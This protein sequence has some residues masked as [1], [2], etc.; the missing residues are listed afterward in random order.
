[1]FSNKLGDDDEAEEEITDPLVI[2]NRERDL[3]RLMLSN[4][5]SIRP[6]ILD[7]LRSTVNPNMLNLALDTKNITRVTLKK[8]FGIYRKPVNRNLHFVDDTIWAFL[9]SNYLAVQDIESDVTQYFELSQKIDNPTAIFCTQ[10]KEEE[11]SKKKTNHEE[12]KE[13]KPRATYERGLANI[14]WL[15]SYAEECRNINE[16]ADSHRLNIKTILVKAK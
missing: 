10:C 13:K 5:K 6:D 2:L 7:R 8:V 4:N 1:M 9:I 16:I 15:F 12:S 11:I 14:P 3:Q